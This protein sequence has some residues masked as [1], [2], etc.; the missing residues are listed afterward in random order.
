MFHDLR[1]KV[2]GEFVYKQLSYFA[3]WKVHSGGTHE[4]NILAS[5]FLLL[6]LLLPILQVG[7][8]IYI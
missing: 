8:T 5:K 4:N 2:D 3:G 6:C 1:H 7:L